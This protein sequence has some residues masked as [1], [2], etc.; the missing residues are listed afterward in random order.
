MHLTSDRA[1]TE[2]AAPACTP[3]CQPRCPVCSGSLIEQ[4]GSLRCACCAYT[5]CDGCGGDAGEAF[6]PGAE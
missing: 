6:A 2:D 4:R 1:R 3:S 5:F